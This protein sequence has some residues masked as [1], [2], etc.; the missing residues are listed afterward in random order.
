MV[1]LGSTVKDILTGFTGIATGRTEWLF[2]CTRIA[3]EPT[4]LKEG[5]PIDAEWF[6]EQRVEVIKKTKP[7]MSET[8]LRSQVPPLTDSPSDSPPGGP[9]KDP[10]R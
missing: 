9:Q 6:D 1:E 3:I 8:F 10:I 5:K 2:G 4:K 7:I